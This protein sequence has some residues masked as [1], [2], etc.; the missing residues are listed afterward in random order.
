MQLGHQSITKAK[1]NIIK[2]AWNCIKVEDITCKQA[3]Y[4]VLARFVACFETKPKIIIQIFVSLLKAHQPETRILVR[5]ALDVLLPI[6]SER[7]PVDS[8]AS[9]QTAVFVRWT[10]KIMIEESHIMSQLMSIY[11]LIIR[12]SP[13]FYTSRDHFIFSIVGSL[14]KLGLGSSSTKEQKSLAIDLA[15]VIVHWEKSEPSALCLEVNS[16]MASEEPAAKKPRLAFDSAPVSASEPSQGNLCEIIL[17]F[18]VKFILNLSDATQRKEIFP[19]SSRLIVEILTAFPESIVDLSPFEKF[20]SLDL[21]ETNQNSIS[22]LIEILLILLSNKDDS[23][24]ISNILQIQNCIQVWIKGDFLGVSK[25]F[26]PLLVRIFK[27]L[28]P[29]NPHLPTEVASFYKIFES[30]IRHSMAQ[31]ESFQ[32]YSTIVLLCL[33]YQGRTTDLSGIY[34]DIMKLLHRLTVEHTSSTINDHVI[35]SAEALI[36]LLPFLKERTMFLGESRKIFMISLV[37]LL[38]KSQDSAV[39]R[40]I[41]DITTEWIYNK[42]EPFPTSKE[43]AN[44][45]CKMMDFNSRTDK[46]L[47]DDYLGLIARIFTD[48]SFL[49]SEL[50]SRLEFAFLYGLDYSNAEIRKRF[51]SILSSSVGSQLS[52]RFNYILGVQNWEP[53]AGQ[54]WIKQAL[55]LIMGSIVSSTPIYS[56]NSVYRLHSLSSVFKNNPKSSSKSNSSIRD[57]IKAHQKFLLSLQDITTSSF[58]EPMSNFIYLEDS[59]ASNLWIDVFTATWELFSGIERT[60]LAKFLNQLLAKDYHLRQ[61]GRY[62]NVIQTLLEGVRRA[63]PHIQVPPQLIKYL[64]KKFNS[65]HSGIEILETMVWDMRIGAVSSKNQDK[66]RETCL[67][68]L[69]DLF[70]K[71]NEDDYNYGVWRSRCQFVETNTALSFEQNG[72]W[73][74]SQLM[75]EQVQQKAK[76]G[77]LPF[78]ESEYNLWE[79]HWVACAQRLQQWDLLTELSK[80]EGKLFFNQGNNDLLI[81]CAWRNVDWVSEKEGVTQTLAGVSD[82][83]PRKKIF[84][85]FSSWTKLHDD[86]G[87]EAAN[88]FQRLCEE[89]VQQS[90]EQWIALPKIVSKAHVPL[91]HSFQQYV[92]FQEVFFDNFRLLLFKRT[93][94]EL[95]LLMLILKQMS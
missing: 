77:V 59:L 52:V 95:I 31:G 25:F 79:D 89:G 5:Q 76:S 80:H 81:E 18:V 30:T 37:V 64:A 27:A 38:D 26:K 16:P 82:L 46:T 69:S 3:A 90:L 60:G 29:L 74:T 93:C 83:N 4:V 7:V 75:F 48:A 51:S 34:G 58:I 91:F 65:W 84:E 50:S 15:E 53:L 17:G 40:S 36:L 43:K 42:N 71:L 23:W 35:Y 8:G 20:A 6:M 68:N 19:R 92:E 13:V 72:R 24:I 61:S 88:E 87:L 12:H 28:A 45:L 21:N 11:Q 78:L 56:T 73:A 85:V 67:D 9:G 1:K 57:L 94:L 62:P 66:V 33:S 2:F 39:L 14:K 10:R 86:R 22:M 63:V 47:L 44:L 41:L 70:Y 54:F 49:R 55:E 32:P